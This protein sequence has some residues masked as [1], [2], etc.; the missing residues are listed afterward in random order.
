MSSGLS[1]M[2]YAHKTTRFEM[3]RERHTLRNA[4]IDSIQNGTVHNLNNKVWEN[5]Q[6]YSV[7]NSTIVNSRSQVTLLN[8]LRYTWILLFGVLKCQSSSITMP[9]VSIRTGSTYKLMLI[10]NHLFIRLSCR[11]KIANYTEIILMV[12][13]KLKQ[14]E[15][16]NINNYSLSARYH[17]I[18]SLTIYTAR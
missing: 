18:S 2:A 15:N 6:F 16:L 17:S 10:I 4:Q 5:C 8:G 12:L 1:G 13:I 11:I 14:L 3:P 9:Q 7:I